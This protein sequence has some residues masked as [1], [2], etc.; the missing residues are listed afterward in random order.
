MTDISENNIKPTGIL[1]GTFDPV[2]HGHL[3]LALEC[4]EAAGLSEVSFI[5]LHTPPHR[6]LAHA[7]PAQRLMMLQLATAGA[8]NLVVDDIEVRKGGTSYTIDT[9]T[10]LRKKSGIRPICLI[11]GMDA[12]R[13][14]SSWKQW[15]LIPE[16]V[17]IIVADRPDAETRIDDKQIA[18]LYTARRTDRAEDLHNSPAGRILKINIPLLTISSTRIR[19][20]LGTGQHPGFLLPDSVLNYI[21]KE[22][23][24]LKQ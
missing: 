2:H 14:F 12:F 1:G 10:E 15:E 9:V 17:H 6:E 4:I 20:M 5:P 13:I 21:I 16:H 24:Y 8:G 7:G 18:R 23:I 3:R 19:N 22:N 11:M